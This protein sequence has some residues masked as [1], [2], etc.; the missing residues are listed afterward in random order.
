MLYYNNGICTYV[1]IH[2]VLIFTGNST[3]IIYTLNDQVVMAMFVQF[4]ELST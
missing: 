2:N 4:S 3:K 1:H